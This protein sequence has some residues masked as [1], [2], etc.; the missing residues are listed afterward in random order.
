M[1]FVHPRCALSATIVTTIVGIG[2]TSSLAGVVGNWDFGAGS[3]AAAA[4]VPGAQ[5]TALTT[6]PY[7]GAY[8]GTPNPPALAFD[9]TAT[10]GIPSLG[11]YAGSVMRVPNMSGRG[12]AA[13]L[14]AQMPVMSNGQLA[15]GGAASK[16][17]RYSVV[18]DVL[19]PAASFGGAP[20]Y[21][22]LF[23]PRAN[24]DGSWFV[25][26]PSRN[27]GSTVAYSA[28][29]SFLP[30]TWYRIAQVM[31]LDAATSAPRCTY[32]ING[33]PVGSIIWDSIVVENQRDADLKSRDLIPD[34]AW[35]IGTLADSAAVLPANQSGF[36]LF[37]DQSNEYGELYVANV[38]FRDDALSPE[39]V[40]GLGGPAGGAIPVPE[41]GSLACVA[42]FV[43]W[44]S[45]MKSLRQ[46]REVSRTPEA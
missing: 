44:L 38:Q 43:V 4:L 8:G 27:V 26:E 11:G 40:L 17:N 21:I 32:F 1:R 28:V 42:S 15:G 20:D 19:V 30:D 14:M 39:A 9:T 5:L 7:Y 45:C 12:A 24:G 46:M 25:R 33:S 13:G 29:N 23:Q 41:P 22:A 2:A 35:S 18:M 10:F 3:L 31:D 37:N 16:L 36:F 6:T 34:G